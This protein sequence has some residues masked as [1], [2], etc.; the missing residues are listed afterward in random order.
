MVRMK[1]SVALILAVSLSLVA[2]ANRES[3]VAGTYAGGND[4]RAAAEK[5]FPPRKRASDHKVIVM[6]GEDFAKR[7]AIL[8]PVIAEYGLSG[9]GGMTVPLKYPESFIVGTK[10]RLAALAE[11][12]AVD[13]VTVVVTVG[14]PEGTL[15]ELN[16]V[17]S[18]NPSMKIVTLFSSDDTLPVEAVSD[19]VC[20]DAR[21][22]KLLSDESSTLAALSADD[23]SLGLL[24]L[25]SVFAAEGI[26]SDGAH[27][28]EATFESSVASAADLMKLKKNAPTWSVA[29]WVDPDTGLKSRKNLSVA[30]VPGVAQVASQSVAQSSS[31]NAS[32]GATP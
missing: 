4:A 32:Q 12:A 20:M 10:T 6:L 3:S 25:A 13:G 1:H 21:D 7:P 24:V 16:K 11:H 14:A 18:I 2:C 8:D 19:I 27:T 5:S 22:D 30:F 28:P 9:F 17:R 31:K 29:P 23:A 26:P 15:A